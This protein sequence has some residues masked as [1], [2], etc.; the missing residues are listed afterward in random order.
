[1]NSYNPSL[2]EES[3]RTSNSFGGVRI[4]SE[5][6]GQVPLPEDLEEDLDIKKK[7]KRFFEGEPIYVE[8]TLNTEDGPQEL[9]GLYYVVDVNP[10]NKR[11]VSGGLSHSQ[12]RVLESADRDHK[13]VVHQ[14]N[15]AYK[16]PV[17]T[18]YPCTHSD[19]PDDELIPFKLK[20][21]SHGVKPEYQEYLLGREWLIDAFGLEAEYV[22]HTI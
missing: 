22:A 7:R 17:D 14:T 4:D 2:V 21:N 16:I 19:V 11:Q 9:E 13:I 8:G 5:K 20:P 12:F 18:K 6:F 3:W 10:R 1:M 15:K